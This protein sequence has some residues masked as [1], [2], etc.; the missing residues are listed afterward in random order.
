MRYIPFDV[1]A[2]HPDL[3]WFIRGSKGRPWDVH[4][5]GLHVASFFVRQDAREFIRAAKPA[6]HPY[7]KN[8]RS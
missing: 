2:H 1:E 3:R 7:S 4:I 5:R 8:A 6:D